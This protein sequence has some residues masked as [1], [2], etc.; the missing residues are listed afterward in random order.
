MKIGVE[1]I[2]IDI[3]GSYTG[4]ATYVRDTLHKYPTGRWKAF[5][6]GYGRL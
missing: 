2:D 6:H 5:C 4:A 1:C 3:K